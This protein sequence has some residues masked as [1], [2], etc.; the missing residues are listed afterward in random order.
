MTAFLFPLLST[1]VCTLLLAS[2]PPAP[3]ATHTWKGG[4]GDN[5]WS[6]AD[7]WTG[8]SPLDD[9]GSFIEV[10]FPASAQS[11]HPVLDNG[12]LFYVDRIIFRGNYTMSMDDPGYD[13]L[14]LEN[15]TG[16]EVLVVDTA[17]APVITFDQLMYV[18]LGGPARVQSGTLRFQGKISALQASSFEG[19]GDIWMEGL[20]RE[21]SGYLEMNGGTLHLNKPQSLLQL[22]RVIAGAGGT[23][24]AEQDFQINGADL[25]AYG[26]LVKLAAGVTDRTGELWVTNNGS[27]QALAVGSALQFGARVKAGDG[28]NYLLGRFLL[29]GV[30]REFFV[31]GTL[32]ISGSLE[33]GA[34]AIPLSQTGGIRK[35]SHGT[36]QINA[37]GTFHGPVIVEEGEVIALHD[38]AFGADGG[39]VTVSAGQRL[40]LK[41]VD[42]TGETLTLAGTLSVPG[43]ASTWTGGVV[44]QSTAQGLDF[45]GLPDPGT[46]TVTGVISGPGTLRMEAPGTLELA[47]AGGNTFTGE[48]IV[49]N[50][51]VRLNKSSGRAIPG[52]L[53]I[54]PLLS[55]FQP[56]VVLA[57]DNQ[58]EYSVNVYLTGQTALLDLASHTQ[59]IGGLISSGTFSG[60]VHLGN[61][62]TATATF[63]VGTNN[64]STGFYGKITGAP[65]MTFAKTGTG[66][67]RLGYSGNGAS[68]YTGQTRVLGGL[69]LVDQYQQV[70]D[71]IVKPGATLAGNG[72][73][74]DVSLEGGNLCACHLAT[75]QVTSTSAGGHWQALLQGPAPQPGGYDQ[76]RV[77]GLLSLLGSTLTATLDFLPTT[78]A[79]FVIIQ[80]DG[81]DPVLGT[82]TGL[83]EGA[84][85][86]LNGKPFTIS[87]HGG[88]GNDV[89]LTYTGVGSD[90]RI[91][92]LSY[93]RA[94]DR[95]HLEA[96]APPGIQC[97][98]QVS[99]SM[100]TWSTFATGTPDAA[101]H[102]K[103]DS[104]LGLH[105]DSLFFRLRKP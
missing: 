76:A 33:D 6:N 73:A 8:G 58:I 2:P 101:G 69:L 47:G 4:G 56:T 17:A 51:T 83:G 27:V 32:T 59:T 14:V 68:T 87:Y 21:A 54:W 38:A 26:G 70:S 20:L 34:Q 35:T 37:P 5:Y 67:L 85:L 102:L 31:G 39:G 46:L 29:G 97:Q 88:D 18:S 89:A 25:T 104:T 93:D 45:N 36:L 95:I 22:T 79:Q 40:T 80:N 48:T 52:P 1:A 24:V 105:A 42:I 75:G 96:L 65:G 10:I 103:L 98:W 84:A 44:L 9:G 11:H 7:N 13:G 15:T 23:V 19:A 49:R 53:T 3:A 50:G 12:G 62:R 92:T 55:H 41:N 82:F 71:V 64:A 77:T 63:T 91:L 78:A 16:A 61:S 60:E 86:T 30:T 28:S 100:S 74:G 90:P 57:A 94:L 43:G 66:T 72:A 99:S 81:T